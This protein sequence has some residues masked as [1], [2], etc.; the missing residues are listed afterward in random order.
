[1]LVV[2]S[3]C[4]SKHKTCPARFFD[5]RVKYPHIYTCELPLIHVKY[6]YIHVWNIFTI[7]IYIYIYRY[8]Y[9]S[10][11]IFTTC[12]ISRVNSHFY[13]CQMSSSTFSLVWYLTDKSQWYSDA[14][15]I[16]PRFIIVIT[17]S[18]IFLF[19][20]TYEYIPSPIN[21]QAKPNTDRNARIRPGK[22][23]SVHRLCHR[24]GQARGY[25]GLHFGSKNTCKILIVFEN[26]SN[27]F[28]FFE[29]TWSPKA[30]SPYRANR[31]VWRGVYMGCSK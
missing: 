22:L 8:I 7:Y 24:A 16:N 25:V 28:V 30:M 17:I 31:R 20:F 5:T 29:L 1:M 3:F 19:C 23:Y 9:V 10:Y 11:I 12:E 14:L 4:F 15:G 13:M 6:P 18:D 21:I 2:S 27:N 26:L